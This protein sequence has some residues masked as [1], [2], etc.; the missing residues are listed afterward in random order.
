MAVLENMGDFLQASRLAHG[1]DDGGQRVSEDLTL[2]LILITSVF[3]GH[4]GR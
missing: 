2:G 3:S 1:S 4:F